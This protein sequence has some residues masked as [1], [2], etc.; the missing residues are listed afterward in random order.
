VDKTWEKSISD[1]SAIILMVRGSSG[2]ESFQHAGSIH[3]SKEES[4]HAT[5][6]KR[7]WRFSME[8]Q[9]GIPV[10]SNWVDVERELGMD[11]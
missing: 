2:A 11:F 4:G 6:L 10:W 5:M 9:V 7:I 1:F 8:S 3:C